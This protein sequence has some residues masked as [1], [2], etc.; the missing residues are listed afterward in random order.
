LGTPSSGTVTNLTGTA[1]ININGTVGAT[2]ASTGAFT[3]LSTTGNV[4]LGDAS[5]DTLNV[6]NGD[7]IKD[8][9]GN[10]GLG[11]TPN[12]WVGSNDVLQFGSFGAITSSQET[13]VYTN[14][15]RNAGAD[16]IYLTSSLGASFYD[17]YN[18]V[19]AWNIAGTGTAGNVIS[20]TQAMTLNASGNLGVGTTSPTFGGSR[21]IHIANSSGDSRLHLT[22]NTTGTTAND[23]TEI[24]VNSGNL[25]IDQK[26][27][28]PILILVSS[29][30]VARFPAAG[31]FQSKT[32]ISVGDAAPSSSGAGITFPATQSA[33]SNANTLD[34]Y[35]EG[36]FTPTVIG[37]TTAGTAS[38]SYNSGS[39]T[40][41]GNLVTISFYIAWSS[42]TG[43][44]D[45]R[46]AGLPFTTAN[47]NDIGALAL[48]Y[49]S[50]LTLTALNYA[51]SRVAVN[52]TQIIFE[53]TPVGGGAV[54]V[55]AYDATAEL[56]VSG[57]Y[58][59]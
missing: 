18:G 19:H 11:A 45:L 6:G 1:S 42:G 44:G 50:N 35:E 43:T 52:S 38:Y 49:V 54:S 32:T 16:Y 4:T 40:K 9:S 46:I 31:G 22:D 3:T 8:A 56:V 15:Y 57:S 48:G 33:S 25:Y 2:T 13:T 36:T 5:T 26:E 17:Q 28:Q 51:T 34:D 20:F 21:G 39:Y 7:L 30:E 29:L 59:V 47:S 41:I 24:V 55:I 14:A 53:Q 58:F 12:A 10:L 37:T 27:S 23:G